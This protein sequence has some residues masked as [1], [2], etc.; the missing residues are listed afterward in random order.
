MATDQQRGAGPPRF[1]FRLR[2]LLIVMT[3]ACVVL[4]LIAWLL[5]TEIPRWILFGLY[6]EIIALIVIVIFV[7]HRSQRLQWQAPT[8]YV[9]VKVDARWMRRVKSPYIFGPVAAL[10]GV[11]VTFAPLG[12]LMC[13]QV[14]EFGVVQWILVPVCFLIIYFVPGFY[15]RL[16]LEVIAEMIK[17]VAPA[18]DTHADG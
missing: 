10:T 18:S 4:G 9:L 17:P 13:G 5:P 14:A 8:D 3:L 11:S 15:M 12:L 1:Q 16:A 6:A 2:T 7:A